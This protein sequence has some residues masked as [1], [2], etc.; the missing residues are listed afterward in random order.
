[1]KKLLILIVLL[2]GFTNQE[3]A[4]QSAYYD[5]LFIR[6]S[7][8]DESDKAFMN[9]SALYK[10]IK[11]YFPPK[12]LLT[13]SHI[14][15]NP[16]LAP[17][18]PDAGIQAA[19]QP[20][21]YIDG[22]IKS[23]GGLDVTH[24]VNGVADFMI[25]RAKEELTITFFDRFKKFAQEH[26]E[27]KVLFPK[28]TDN[29]V[30][31]LTYQYPQMLPVL[32][33]GFMEDLGQLT[34]RLDDVLELPRYNKLLKDFPEVRVAIRSLQL[35]HE[36]ERNEI[37]VAEVIEQFSTFAEWSDTTASLTLRNMGNTIH[38]SAIFSNSLR[39]AS[40]V[41]VS[42]KEVKEMFA[43]SVL[44]HIY[45]GLV[46]QQVQA[47]DIRFLEESRVTRFADILKDQK[48]DLFL[49]RNKLLE[50][51]E[52]ADRVEKQVIGIKGTM[53]N[54]AKPSNDDYFTY[55]RTCTDVMEY[56][57]NIA[58]LFNE[59]IKTKEYVELA[60][61]SNELYKNI[62][63]QEYPQAIVNSIDLL[64]KIFS[65]V[66]Q[67]PK[68]GRLTDQEEDDIECLEDFLTHVPKF[69]LFMAN[70][71]A[72]K[73][74]EEV[75]AALENA[76]LPVGSSSIKKNTNFNIS[77]QS[78]LGAYTAVGPYDTKNSA[79]QDRFGVLAPIGVSFSTGLGK[80]GSISL[81][82]TLFDLGAIVDYKL[83]ADS[84]QGAGGVIT[85]EIQKDYKIQ[86]GQVVSPGA[87]LVYGMAWNI[88]LSVGF[89]GQY[90]P[91]LTKIDA[92]GNTNVVNPAWRW[93]V[94]VSV[95]IPFFNLFTIRK[96]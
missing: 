20:S 34:Y 26:E 37:N 39:G 93:N 7:C 2:L 3:L 33:T 84:V 18:V 50:F 27:F 31:L 63:L 72:A 32:R 38:L 87:Y 95:D 8:Y 51:I 57:F 24:I 86:L 25:K 21:S 79:W 61:K 55:V 77:V 9:K 92:G 16:F 48:K 69:A 83:T 15:A 54:G 4:Q 53:K 17:Y 47:R 43:D 59:N 60:R 67:N 58:Y 22:M 41:W 78:Y 30:H 65:M 23:A 64:N 71:A 35:V 76:A 74:S 46:Y 94:F 1:M 45:L 75:S 68:Y 90:G 40:R 73:S 14:K 52:L 88:P 12:T 11:K 42:P 36:L 10:V 19:P 56:S 49:L 44:F 96:K 82:P 80:G 85:Q 89:G 62:Y 70:V 91:G 29:L 66:Q 81:F 28:T 5:A 6:D 13:D